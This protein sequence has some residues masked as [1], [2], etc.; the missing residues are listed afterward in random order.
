MSYEINVSKNGI[1]YFATHGRSLNGFEEDAIKMAKHFK[2][3]FPESDGYL[4]TL[5]EYRTM[6]GK[7][8]VNEHG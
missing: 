8:E 6:M 3:V 5:T 7:I 1:H 2:S 4:V